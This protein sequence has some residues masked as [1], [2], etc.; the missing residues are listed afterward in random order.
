MGCIELH[1][2]DLL[3]QQTP[4]GGKKATVIS[5]SVK[6]CDINSK[7]YIITGNIQ[8]VCTEET[9]SYFLQ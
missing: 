7:M 2:S 1:L 6:S 5:L 9:E 3:A 4:V 8:N